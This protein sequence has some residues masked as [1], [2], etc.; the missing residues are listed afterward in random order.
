MSTLNSEVEAALGSLSEQ[1]GTLEDDLRGGLSALGQSLN[2]PMAHQWNVTAVDGYGGDREFYFPITIP[3]AVIYRWTGSLEYAQGWRPTQWA[4]LGSI[5]PYSSPTAMMYSWSYGENPDAAEARAKYNDTLPQFEAT[6]EATVRDVRDLIE[7]PRKLGSFYTQ[8]DAA[9]A[10]MDAVPGRITEALQL[11]R[12]GLT[13]AGPGY[14]AYRVVATRQQ[15]IANAVR[16]GINDT[17]EDVIGFVGLSM[18]V[19]NT[20]KSAADTLKTGVTNAGQDLLGVLTNRRDWLG[21]VNLLVDAFTEGDRLR[22]DAALT[23]A[24][25]LASIIQ[26]QATIDRHFSALRGAAGV[27]SMADV[28]WPQPSEDV[29]LSWEPTHRS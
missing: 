27:S 17:L 13:W 25:N 6:T 2:G 15:D 14:E 4:S 21:V 18:D 12:T 1:L 10:K 24:N 26:R 9:R 29:Q 19:V 7:L 23:G 8:W 3:V 20:L 11:D 5:L 16:S 28:A 22:S